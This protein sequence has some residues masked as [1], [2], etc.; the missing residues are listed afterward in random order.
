MSRLRLSRILRGLI[1]GLVFL[2][3]LP[4]A[5]QDAG[6]EQID[7]ARYEIERRIQAQIEQLRQLHS[8]GR[9]DEVVRQATALLELD[10][11]NRAARVWLDRA[12]ERIRLQTAPP[13]PDRLV[14]TEPLVEPKV[15]EDPPVAPQQATVPPLDYEPVPLSPRQKT[16]ALTDN[17]SSLVLIALAAVAV[18]F[19]AIAIIAWLRVRASQRQLTKAIAQA[20]EKKAQQQHRGYPPAGGLDV[21]DAVTQVQPMNGDLPQ[22]QPLDDDDSVMQFG[23]VGVSD[24]TGDDYMNSY[25]QSPAPAPE[26]IADTEPAPRPQSSIHEEETLLD[27]PKPAPVDFSEQST[28]LDFSS[29]LF[30]LPPTK[31]SEEQETQDESE[32][33]NFGS[34]LLNQ[35]AETIVPSGPPPQEAPRQAE[36]RKPEDDAL[37]FNSLMFEGA[38]ETKAPGDE[39]KSEDTHAQAEDPDALTFNSL[40]FSGADE[41]RLPGQEGTQGAAPQPEEEAG[42]MTFNS[43]MFGSGDETVAPPGVF[44]APP[45]APSADIGDSIDET[46]PLMA[47]LGDED[48][49]RTVPLPGMT[50]SNE[51][52]LA[53]PGYDNRSDSSAAKFDREKKEGIGALTRGDYKA[54]VQALTVAAGLRPEDEEV[55]RRLEEA[56]RL[57]DEG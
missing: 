4:V 23:E 50:G 25:Q 51:E 43:M 47:G 39:R 17:F 30:A 5:A 56:R 44:S 13:E 27:A 10:P 24:E 35:E 32:E 19:V 28:S 37:S 14:R 15:V 46:V 21:H 57:R 45:A 38:A 22:T 55:T 48:L 36:N 12:N 3:I 49:E 41:T 26:E 52:T 42:E 34:M 29:D 53:L 31:R 2:P 6:I 8:E 1:L 11:D 16:S 33:L 54:A 7:Q 20:E 40:M 18:L 9:Y